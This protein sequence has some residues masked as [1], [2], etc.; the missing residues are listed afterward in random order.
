MNQ[1]LSRLRHESLITEKG[2]A[3]EEALRRSVVDVVTDSREVRSG[4]L[5][6]AIS[7]TVADGHGFL[8]DAA[9]RGALAALVERPDPTVSL[10]QILVEDGRIAAAFAAAEAW[11]NPSEEL[12]LVGVT[13][14][15]GKTTTVAILRHLLGTRGAAASLGTLGAIGRD[16]TVIPGTEGL[17]TPGPTEVARLLRRLLDD[18]IQAVAMEVSSH[19]LQ[20]HRVA[21]ARFDVGVF[22]NLSREHLDYH[23]DMDAYRRAKLRLLELLKPGG[24]AVVNTDDPA[25]RGVERCG[26]R[27]VSF[28][29]EQSADVR[30]EDVVADRDGTRWRLTTPDGSAPVRL[31]LWGGY[32]VANAL[33]AGAALWTLGWQATEIAAGLGTVPQVPGRL[34]R[35]AGSGENNSLVLI[36]YAHTPDALERA[37]AAIRPLVRNRLIVVFGAGGDRDPGKRPEMGRI[38]AAGAD[39]AIVTS[40]NP[41][42]EDPVRIVSAIEAGMGNAPRLRIPDR[43]EAIE[44]ALEE[45]TKRDVVLLAG[46]GHETYQIRGTEHHPFDERLIVQD[47][48]AKRTSSAS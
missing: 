40:D 41:R 22:T 43:R 38:A 4:T 32:N 21:A 47:I 46:K 37:L 17:T 3:D 36:D 16:G 7:G 44:R 23:G 20:Q 28:G 30:A 42:T 25:W 48:L 1:I 2:A 18:G 9:R 34:E 26:A 27:T 8:G 14:T 24:A 29:I 39:L 6:C 31:P 11:G 5:F 10:L 35:V 45:A 13:G 15:N 12:T 19:A 33:A